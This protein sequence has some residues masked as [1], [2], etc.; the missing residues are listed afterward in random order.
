V[1]Q[2][3]DAFGP[4]N[5]AGPLHGASDHAGDAVSSDEWSE[6]GNVADEHVVA[7]AGSGATLEIADDCVSDF[8]RQWQRLRAV[9][10][11]LFCSS[12]RNA[13]INGASTSSNATR[14][15]GIWNRFRAN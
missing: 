15:G 1:P 3:V 11:R 14:A 9:M 8:L 7:P 2:R 5:H 10:P 6:G 4:A 13:L 12:S